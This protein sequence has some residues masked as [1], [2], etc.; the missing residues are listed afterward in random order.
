MKEWH[1]FLAASRALDWRDPGTLWPVGVTLSMLLAMVFALWTALAL[2][3]FVLWHI[4]YPLWGGVSI[5]WG[6][7]YAIAFALW[8]IKW[9]SK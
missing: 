4:L 1:E 2:P 7:A 5:N 8:L 3:I 6:Q 9:W